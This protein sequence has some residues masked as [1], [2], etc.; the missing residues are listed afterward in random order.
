MNRKLAPIPFLAIAMLLASIPIVRT[1]NTR[2][3]DFSASEIITQIDPKPVNPGTRRIDQGYTFTPL[4]IQNFPKVQRQVTPTGYMAKLNHETRQQT[5]RIETGEGHGS[6]V[7]V[8]KQ[9]ST[10]YV[11]TVKH[12]VETKLNVRVIAHDRE[13]YQIQPSNIKSANG[14]DLAVV[15]FTTSTSLSASSNTNYPVAKIGNYSPQADATVFVGGYPEREKIDSPLWQWQLNP[16]NIE[17]KEQGKLAVQDK[18]SFSNGYDLIYSSISYGGMSGGPIFDTD[19][20]LIGIHGK[21]EGE[22]RGSK[23]LITG[24]SLGISIQT[25]LGLTERLQVPKLSKISSNIPA[26]LSK[27]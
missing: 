24:Q 19:G 14:V 17:D 18:Q 13:S 7:I 27:Q 10:Y 23:E 9:G 2:D 22:R 4:Q 6:G 21:V 26:N 12:V 16:G 15:K 3:R 1:N 5:V 20:R 8:A 11:L 25:F